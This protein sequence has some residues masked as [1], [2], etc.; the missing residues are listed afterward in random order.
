LKGLWRIFVD[1]ASRSDVVGQPLLVPLETPIE[2]IDSMVAVFGQPQEVQGVLD[3]ASSVRGCS[4][5]VPVCVKPDD[6]L[7]LVDA[8]ETI[9]PTRQS[10]SDSLGSV[11]VQIRSDQL[12]QASES[13]QGAGL[14]YCCSDT[15]LARADAEGEDIAIKFA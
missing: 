6:R 11:L 10:Q 9:T 1:Q 2:D 7:D 12:V 5:A 13:G 8:V 15:S 4:E 14:C 3:G